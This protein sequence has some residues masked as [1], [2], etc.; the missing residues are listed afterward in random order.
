VPATAYQPLTA[1]CIAA[2]AASAAYFLDGL[3]N[4]VPS[5]SIVA[6][7]CSRQAG[8]PGGTDSFNPTLSIRS[9]AAATA[10]SSCFA[11]ASR[12]VSVLVSPV[13]PSRLSVQSADASRAVCSVAAETIVTWQASTDKG[14]GNG[15]PERD[16]VLLAN[17]T[18]ALAASGGVSCVPLDGATVWTPGECVSLG[19]FCVW[20]WWQ[21]VHC[22]MLEASDCC[23]CNMPFESHLHAAATLPLSSSFVSRSQQAARHS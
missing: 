4:A 21:L 3:V 9:T 12:G 15:F 2:T 14:S 20:Y 5:G 10:D 6:V 8:W 11:T 19:W 22:A 17:V 23:H 18:L 7:N 13:G 1:T 16:G